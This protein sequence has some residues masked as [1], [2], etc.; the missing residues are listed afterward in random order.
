MY[1]DF[2]CFTFL[3]Y[4]NAKISSRLSVYCNGKSHQFITV[5]TCYS[6]GKYKE[7][8]LT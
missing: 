7:M 8:S 4:E 5:F 6:G 3:R 2:I 1:I